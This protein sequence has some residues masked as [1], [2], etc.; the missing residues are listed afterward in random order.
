MRC[1]YCSGQSDRVVDSRSVA[2]G[3]A[4][5]RRRECT[6]CG[7][8]YTTYEYVEHS[9]LQVV[10]NDGKR[11]EFNRG[12]LVNGIMLACKKRPVSKASID[13]IG[14]D[15]E[16]MVFQE[17]KGE[18]TSRRIGELVMDKLRELDDIAY[19]R[20]AS[21]YRNFRDKDEFLEEL[22]ELPQTMTVIKSNGGRQGF[23]RGKMIKGI[24]MACNKRPVS[25]E[26]IEKIADKVISGLN[27]NDKGEVGSKDI[28]RLIS[29]ELRHIDEVA[30]VRFA[31]VYRN[32][33][34][35]SEFLNQL[36][37]LLGD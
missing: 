10:K 9:G 22:K 1:P 18:V 23:D 33:Q 27:P 24:R 16:N 14:E 21:V 5:R 34:D 4:V 17:S 30:Y 2:G 3:E 19:V 31:S 36:K 11:E 20:F 25:E 8:R 28:G 37:D 7:K 6:S 12:K 29:E 26:A 15:I 13:K 32:F 35:K